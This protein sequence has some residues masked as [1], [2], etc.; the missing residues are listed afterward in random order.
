MDYNQLLGRDP[1]KINLK[2]YLEY[3]KEKRVLITGAGGSIGSEIAKQMITGKSQA[4]R[5]Y[6]FGHGENSIFEIE[7][8]LK[9]LNKNKEI[10]A[11]PIIG[12]IQDRE[13]VHWLIKRLSV[14]VVFHTAA[15]KHVPM[16][17]KNPV[18]AIKNNVFGTKNLVDACKGCCVSKFIMI[19][20]DK[21]VEPINIYGASK[22]LAEEIVL[23]EKENQRFLIVR[24]GNVIGSKGSAIPLFEELIQNDEPIPIT[25]KGIRRY[26]MTIQEAVS[27]VLKIGSVGKGGEIYIL[28]MGEPISIEKLAKKLIEIYNKKDI[29]VVYT[30]LRL[31]EKEKEKLW[32]NVE[33][34]ETTRYPKILRLKKKI[35]MNVEDVLRELKPVCFYDSHFVSFYRNRK[36]LKRILNKYIPTINPNEEREY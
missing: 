30:G 16:L 28:D 36:E 35:F 13:Y 33:K 32:A 25:K 15:H 17:E 34:V 4:S 29:K 26:F 24:F 27:L 21:S 18:E 2:Q 20:S 19:S 31:G 1:I 9:R 23:R 10:K 14:D 12:E 6:L 11:I 3:V 8:K 5:L 22:F 7:R